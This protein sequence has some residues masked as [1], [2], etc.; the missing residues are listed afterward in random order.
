[1]P[2]G[3]KLRLSMRRNG[4]TNTDTQN[5][6]YDQQQQKLDIDDVINSK[7]NTFYKRIKY[8]LYKVC[9]LKIGKA[10]ISFLQKS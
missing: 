9:L 8:V 10:R 3:H 6:R 5:I 1:M 2:C 7:A 4:Q